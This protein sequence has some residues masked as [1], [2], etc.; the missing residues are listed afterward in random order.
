MWR[1]ILVAML[2]GTA[3]ADVEIT[4]IDLGNGL[5]WHVEAGWGYNPMPEMILEEIPE[6]NVGTI[7]P[8]DISGLMNDTTNTTME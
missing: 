4:D 6:L 5:A 1:L 3:S 2:I 7:E 8:Y